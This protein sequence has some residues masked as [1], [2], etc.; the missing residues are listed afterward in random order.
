MELKFKNLFE[1]RKENF[2]FFDKKTESF[3]E[4]KN[5]MNN[6][7]K[8]EL[9]LKDTIYRDSKTSHFL[10]NEKEEKKQLTYKIN[11][12]RRNF[13]Q[14]SNNVKEKPVISF[15]TKSDNEN[16]I[17]HG[18]KS[19]N[20]L[21]KETETKKDSNHQCSFFLKQNAGQNSNSK[22]NDKISSF[23]KQKQMNLFNDNSSEKENLR[24]GF[25]TKNCNNKLKSLNTIDYFNVAFEFLC[26]VNTMKSWLEVLLNEEIKQ[27]PSSLI[28][29]V[30]NG[31]YFAKLSNLV[32]EKKKPV[33]ISDKKLVFKHTENINIYFQLLDF[34]KVPE[35]F[36][37]DLTDLYDAKNL[38]KVW[39]TLYTVAYILNEMNP[40][41]Y[42]KISYLDKN[43]VFSE[44]EVLIAK[45]YLTGISFPNFF[46]VESASSCLRNNSNYNKP[47]TNRNNLFSNQESNSNSVLEQHKFNLKKSNTMEKKIDYKYKHGYDPLHKLNCENIILLQSLCRGS[48]FRFNMFVNKI[49]LK[50]YTDELNIFFSIIRGSLNYKRITFFQDDSYP[51]KYFLIDFQSRI[52][53]KLQ[54][55]KQ[56]NLKV[57][58]NSIFIFQSIILGFLKRKT[59]R[60]IKTE[61]SLSSDKLIILQAI[62]RKI[63]SYKK[64]DH[65]KVISN[66]YISSLIEFQSICK[67][68]LLQKKKNSLFKCIINHNICHLQANIRLFFVRC[69]LKKL[70]DSFDTS[71]LLTIKFQNIIRS[72]LLRKHLRDN[73]LKDLF[74]Y[75][76][77]ITDFCSK[78]K[79][80]FIRASV[81][82]KYK[83][84]NILNLRLILRIQS[85]AKGRLIRFQIKKINQKL[86]KSKSNIKVLQ[87]I[88][89]GKI[90]HNKVKAIYNCYIDNTSL[91]ILIQSNIKTYLALK[92]F[93]IFFQKKKIPLTVI[94]CYIDLLNNFDDFY[95]NETNILSL[96][97]RIIESKINNDELQ[98][99]VYNLNL[100]FRLLK[101]AKFSI[102]SQKN[103]NDNSLELL[104]DNTSSISNKF[105]R[106]NRS[107][108]NR[109]K[110]YKN[111]LFYFQLDFNFFVELYDTLDVRRK[112]SSFCI[113]LK[114][115]IHTLFPITFTIS[116]EKSREEYIFLKLIIGLMINEFKNNL[117]NTILITKNKH[118]FWIDF[119]ID[120]NSHVYNKKILKKNFGKF[121][122]SILNNPNIDFECNS[123]KVKNKNNQNDEALLVDE[124]NLNYSYL[125]FENF[126]LEI[127]SHVSKNFDTL[128]HF[129]IEFFDLLESKITQ[130][131]YYIRLICKQI[132]ILSTSLNLNDKTLSYINVGVIFFKY[133]IL[134]I[135][136]HPES[137]NL[138]ENNDFVSN[139]LRINNMKYLKYVILKFFLKKPFTETFLIKLN[140][141]MSSS[142]D[143]INKILN[144]L[145]TIKNKYQN[146]YSDIF[147]E[148]I[149]FPSPQL[150]I[151]FKNILQ[152]E[153]VL[154]KNKTFLNVNKNEVISKLLN[155][156]SNLETLDINDVAF[157]RLSEIIL[158]LTPIFDENLLRQLKVKIF[159]S[160]IKFCLFYCINVQEENNLIKLLISNVNES[161]QLK[162][163]KLK[164][165]NNN[166]NNE[167]R[168]HK[169]V[170]IIPYNELLSLSYKKFKKKTLELILNLESFSKS[171]RSTFLQNILNQIA[172]DIKSKNYWHENQTKQIKSLSIILKSSLEKEEI[173]KKESKD[174]NQLI[175]STLNYSQIKFNEKKIFNIIPVFDKQYFY[176]REL[177]KKNKLPEFGSIKYS[178]KKLFVKNI[179][180]KVDENMMKLCSDFSKL[181]FMFNSHKIG[182]FV[183]E[184]I[185][186]SVNVPGSFFELS[187]DQILSYMDSKK[188]TIEFLNKS[189]VFHT[190]NLLTFIFNKF[191]SN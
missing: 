189:V 59:I 69:Y 159:L 174:Q 188:T 179:L 88:V 17:G 154:F 177:R 113:N 65:T 123:L 103:N 191:F 84:F 176:Q 182:K 100:K 136:E 111:L 127:K 58:Y 142:Q 147:N 99:C 135:I 54:N 101:K 27:T 87:S 110:L 86:L 10:K 48:T 91:I 153:K 12:I 55:Q 102:A 90:I 45:K 139:N 60:K 106:I 29:Y 36:R 173:L 165:L 168:N 75:S 166:I 175:E 6:V 93:R 104:D 171:N 24:K 25:Y 38:P 143:K 118:C 8:K 112:Q 67:K 131:P 121:I 26:R 56:N 107:F 33:F 57:F 39:F 133:Y 44:S 14:L 151:N 32:M 119:L 34:L 96:K 21:Q 190:F 98:N 76:K 79:T 149:F 43:V 1:E 83:S 64:N 141:L 92:N 77:L 132:Y 5:L 42:P 62:M 95:K 181:M 16:A 170:G 186:N 72:C 51:Y 23:V 20:N 150:V 50:S 185:V 145:I 161:H 109:I 4:K 35:L 74:T 122:L 82:K 126:D 11:K 128:K 137:Y 94:R 2:I 73:I 30:Q 66:F 117:Q 28:S 115:F 61:L 124:K 85:I 157:S 108:H 167:N 63:I 15:K 158:N 52:R 89:R 13:E 172:F 105:S 146:F 78:I 31:I 97:N 22:K 160:Q 164:N 19:K 152:F 81:N 162:F 130:I 80:N 47:Q 71:L 41:K 125:Y 18:F 53:T 140:D 187:I 7:M 184:L 114:K 178:A 134:P 155:D 120:L 148:L 40:T 163:N 37:F 144:Q 138:V 46:S 116:N 156:L 183:I 180:L 3:N 49:M 169:N 9:E 68:F 70:V 129:V